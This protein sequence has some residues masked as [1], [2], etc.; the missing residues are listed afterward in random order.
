MRTPRTNE[1]ICTPTRDLTWVPAQRPNA[2]APPALLTRATSM[3]STTRKMKM[4]ALSA[5]A[6]TMPSP[7][8]VS[9]VVTGLKPATSR[10]PMTMPTK[11]ETYTSLVTS[12]K[13]MAMSAG[14]K[15]QAV[16]TNSTS[17]PF[18]VK[19]GD[20]VGRQEGAQTALG[21]ALDHGSSPHDATV[22]DVFRCAPGSHGPGRPSSFGAVPFRPAPPRRCVEL[23]M[24]GAPLPMRV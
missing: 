20:M 2:A 8:M 5:T 17:L 14:A 24:K 1:A 16:L 3:P 15:A 19:L 9:S 7:T 11:S 23:L 22:H 4:P 10:A 12:A 13:T 18:C 21:L 6:G